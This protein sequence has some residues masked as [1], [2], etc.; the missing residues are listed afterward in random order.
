M[1]RKLLFWGLI[2]IAHAI[3]AQNSIYP[4]KADRLYET[5]E[6]LMNQKEYGA[7]RKSFQ[8]FLLNYEQSDFKKG[9]A[10]Y[11]QALCALLLYHFDGEKLIE[12][13]IAANPE[14]PKA[15][16][17]YYELASFYYQEK[18]FSKASTYFG[19]TDFRSLSSDQQ[20]LGRFRWGYSLFN[21]KKLAEALDQFNYYKVTG[22]QY[23]PAGSYYAGFIE[24][25]MG[26]YD[27]AL[28]DFKRAAQSTSYATIVPVMIA[29][30]YY[31]QQNYNELLT[32]IS[33][34]GDDDI[35]NS[36]ELALL[37]GE[38]Y[39]KKADYTNA[40]DGYEEYLEGRE[41]SADR[42]ILF[43][44]GLSAF[45]LNRK[46]EALNYLKSSAAKRDSIGYYAS[47]YLGVLYLQQNQKPLALTAFDLVRN[48][49]ENPDLVEE[50]TF[51]YAKISYDLGFPDQSIKEFEGFLTT[52]PN[53]EYGA[54]VKELLSQAYV[55]ANN[56]NRAIEYIETMPKRNI[57]IDRAYQKA[58]YL[59]ASELFNKGAYEEAVKFFEKSLAYPIEQ[60]YAADASFWCGETYSIGRKYNQAIN[61]YQRI[62][63]LAGYNDVDV[64]GK[65]RYG[66][67]YANFNLKY[68][69]KAL[70]NFKEFV[71]KVPRN[72]LNLADGTLRL[73][74]CY[75]VTKSYSEALTNYRKSIQLKT[76]DEDYAR[77]Q[78]G[79]ISGIERKYQEA[80]NEF[81]F[82][83][84]NYPTSRFIDEAMFQ[85]GQMDF[86]QGK[87]AEAASGYSLLITRIKTSSFLPY[88]HIRRAASYYNLKDY[89][90]TADD[91]AFVLKQYPTHPATKDIILPLQE[92]LNL[93]NRSSEFDQY[94]ALYKTSNPDSK[95]VE[96]IEFESAK[97]L[98]FNQEYGRAITGLITYIGAYPESGRLSEAKYYLGE[99][100]FRTR[101]FA[102][103]K[104]TYYDLSSD[105]TF[106]QASKVIGRIAEIE[107]REGL[108]QA[109]I[110][111][112][113]KLAQMATTKKDQYN[114]WS[115]L[116]ESYYYLAQYDSVNFYAKVIL[117]KG[118]VNAGAQNKASL[119]LG[120]SAMGKGD[121]ESA[122]DEFINTL[123]SARDEYGA[124]AKY[125]L[126]EIFYQS[127]EYKQCYET[128]V[129]LNGEFSAY[130]IWVGKGYLL[131]ADNAIAT[132]D[133]FQAKA[134]LN[135]LIEH[136][137]EESIKRLAIDKL[138]LI[139]DD[140]LKTD[141]ENKKDSIEN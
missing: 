6:Q 127:K 13:F 39:F 52:Y 34:L 112:F 54:D 30:T 99:S 76:P 59:K 22:G 48:F 84:K 66:L 131:L 115:G 20:M 98:Y 79:V 53:S 29:N 49:K 60:N 63:G 101:N 3:V 105:Q 89:A 55:N 128:L 114:A 7:A 67:G 136:F 58:T 134:T 38:A 35:S 88:A 31:K 113:R 70:F 17:A 41:R 93:A 126:G 37:K 75:Y 87:Y 135:S 26:D 9:N 77:L 11:Y 137:P 2:F 18:N 16:S 65:T 138:K 120:K 44:A 91:Y 108:Y 10:E 72:N 132:G 123:N 43:R 85:R 111:Q 4:G 140:E 97:S 1:L 23:G 71:N 14:H 80:I 8:E 61:H 90:K 50:S 124:E 51:Q 73:A 82:V 28:T 110:P 78:A 119:Y 64:I 125:L 68:Y 81:D 129:S 106:A 12:E 83:I 5:G 133:I 100:Y 21:Q 15:I 74:D 25:G 96:S 19:K 45:N 102:K 92:A 27:N 40:L 56:Y 33:A 57:A 95:G 86:E 104:A 62:I 69:D 107:F 121:Y 139:N 36:D 109:A 103:A 32:Y 47:Y 122:K 42:G 130:P 141:Q 94:F 24:F 116:M 46:E 117:E 118:N